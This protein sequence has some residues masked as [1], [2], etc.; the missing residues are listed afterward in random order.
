MACATFGKR[1]SGSVGNDALNHPGRRALGRAIVM[2]SGLL[3]ASCATAPPPML[4]ST[5]PGQLPAGGQFATRDDV[6]QPGDVLRIRVWRQE[7]FSGDFT[8][9]PD[10]V[11]VH[12]LYQNLK[13]A[14]L[15]LSDARER[16]AEFLATFVQG[17]DL[18]V[19]PLYPVT[20]AGEVRQPNLYHVARGTTVAQAIGQAGG[21][22]TQGRLDKIIL[23]RGGSSMTIGITG[24]YSQWGAAP[25]NSGDQLFVQRRSEF[26]FLRDVFQPVTSLAILILNIVRVS[27]N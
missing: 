13:V 21:V 25:V 9:G 7:E 1:A 17:A 6:L 11:L 8:I 3:L 14:G 12:P 24:D 2:L 26:S 16:V 4:L 18:V 19:E 5:F 22:T 20:V 10:S 23:Q 15:R 27:Q